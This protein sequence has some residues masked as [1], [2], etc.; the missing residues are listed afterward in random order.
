M[1]LTE[2]FQNNKFVNTKGAQDKPPVSTPSQLER[3][4]F[5]M[6]FPLTISTANPNNP[7]MKEIPEE[8]RKIDYEEAFSQFYNVYSFIISEGALAYLLPNEGNF[9]DQEYVA[10]LGIYLP[11]LK[12]RNVIV[13]SNFTSQPRQGEEKVGQKFL[14]QMKYDVHMA[15]TKW[16][17]EADLK[18]LRE[19]IYVG[20]YGLRTKKET[21][22]WMEEKFDMK[23]I[24]IRMTDK[25]L[26]HFDTLFL[27]LGP[28][29]V[30]IPTS[31]LE[32][33][34]IKAI[35]KYAEIVDLPIDVAATGCFNAV[36]CGKYMMY[37]DPHHL[38]TAPTP[39][40]FDGV[41]KYLNIVQTATGLKPRAFN[42]NQFERSGA[43]MGCLIMHLNYQGF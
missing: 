1:L 17:G 42:L 32:K 41:D 22:E 14:K 12:D 29:K 38:M 30:L 25:K 28:N 13:L 23:V 15:P 40:M 34:D 9:Q 18:Y 21:Y 39:K 43:D 3:Q 36:P 16:E 11:H 2:F 8:K 26:Y 10:N 31:V 37:A 4:V 7:W 24:P 6:A 19:N 33:E 35:E 5:L 27:R 20:G